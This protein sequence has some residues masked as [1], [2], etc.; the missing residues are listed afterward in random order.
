MLM[1]LFAMVLWLAAALACRR[2]P[3]GLATAA[4]VGLTVAGI[5]MLGAVTLA[6]GPLPGLAGLV[7]GTALLLL[8]PLPAGTQGRSAL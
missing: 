5:P 4:R 7:M 3:A 2:L 6:H 8:M 1:T